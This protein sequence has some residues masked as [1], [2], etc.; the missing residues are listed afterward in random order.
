MTT[1]VVM[2]NFEHLALYTL[3]LCTTRCITL[4]LFISRCTLSSWY[5]H[6]LLSTWASNRVNSGG[7]RLS[8]NHVIM[9]TQFP[10]WSSWSQT[11]E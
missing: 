10:R 9:S 6:H 7:K 8:E 2:A 4:M 11:W 5:Q 3:W 1:I